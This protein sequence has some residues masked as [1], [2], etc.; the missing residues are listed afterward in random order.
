MTRD[1]RSNATRLRFDVFGR[2][3]D[4]ERVQHAWVAFVPGSDG[5]RRPA[6]IP[7]PAEL[8]ANGVAR[9]LDD[10]FHEGASPEHPKVRL[11]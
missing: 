10:V 6:N 5:K 2:R 8:D 3:V 9:Y 11:L 4:V 7:I 1:T